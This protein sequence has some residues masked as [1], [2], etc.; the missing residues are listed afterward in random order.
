MIPKPSKGTA[1]RLR[2]AR[3]RA[4]RRVLT[5][6]APQVLERD[7]YRCRLCGLAWGLQVHHVVYRS[8]GGGHHSG[9]LV[10][11]CHICHGDVHAGRVRLAGDADGKLTVER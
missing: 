10:S 3:I 6:T 8:R 9:N 5:T 2:R 1:R 11:L 4:K 7:G